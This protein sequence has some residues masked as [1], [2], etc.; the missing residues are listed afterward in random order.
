[1]A[2]CDSAVDAVLVVSQLFPPSFTGAEGNEHAAGESSPRPTA[3]FTDSVMVIIVRLF[4]ADRVAQFALKSDL[5]EP[6]SQ[7]RD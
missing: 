5:A 6:A 3:S 1:M 2:C 7:K 4:L